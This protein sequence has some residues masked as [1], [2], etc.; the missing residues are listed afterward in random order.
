MAP[1]WRHGGTVQ[2]T[3]NTKGFIFAYPTRLVLRRSTC[4][5]LGANCLIE[6]D[7]TQMYP[8]GFRQTHTTNRGL[9]GREDTIDKTVA[10]GKVVVAVRAE[11]EISKTALTW[12][13]THV[14]R[15]GD[16]ITLLAVF[17]GESRG[18]RLW[19][20]PRFA[21]DC[22]GSHRET[23]P[24]RIYQIS[25]SCSQMVLQFHDQ[26]EV[27]IK[28][29]MVVSG[30]PGGAV[31]EESKRAGANWV[32]LDK[33]LK[34]EEKRCMEELHCNIVVMKHSQPKI[35][36]LNLGGSGEIEPSF[37]SSLE[38]ESKE[39]LESRVKH[40]TP[41]SSPEEPRTSFTRTTTEEASLSSSEA[42][43]SPFFVCERNPLFE[44]L[45]TGN[46]RPIH[47]RF[48]SD[49]SFSSFVL[50]KEDHLISSNLTSSVTRNNVNMYWIHQNHAVDK[51]NSVIKNYNTTRNTKNPT[52]KTLLE[53][54]VQF[55]VEEKIPE[56][57]LNRTPRIDH[58]FNSDVRDAV[59]LSRISSAPPPLCSLCRHRAPVFGKP[60]RWFDYRELEDATNG[61]SEAN[62]LA[63]GGF[64]LVH[65]GVLGDG[66]M[67]AVKQLKISGSQGDAE[68]RREV[69][70]LSC[71]QHRNVVMLVGF[72]IEGNKRVLVYEYVC[73]SSLDF[74]LYGQKRT[75]LD[76]KSRLKIAIGAA[77]GL[78]YL[79]EDCRVGCIV[80]RD[81]RPNNI[82]LT[83]DFEPLVADFGLARWQP[84]LDDGEEQ[85]V[86]GTLGY[87]APE[88]I[89]GEK[90]TEKADVYAFGVVLLE[91]ITGRKT[92][93]AARCKGQKFLAEC[94]RPQLVPEEESQD[95]AI[96]HQLLDPCLESNQLHNFSYQLRAMAQGA[97]L[98][99]RRDP[100]S[101]PSMSKVSCLYP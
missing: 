3:A 19:S 6:S 76:W 62:L 32:V 89:E 56:H 28:I 47:R 59:F 95:L 74:H 64:G 40:S 86:I 96:N 27:G 25:E 48:D 34:Q 54:F 29:K 2:K 101:R 38:L 92:I 20:F 81:M 87:L 63:E 83:H 36:R 57:G 100:E 49:Q 45:S 1:S 9:H 71:A 8:A 90:I 55:D 70:V 14:V 88:Y 53:K 99:L 78:R 98:C 91:L 30:S 79:H 58:V 4:N 41:V 10:P 39:L 51:Q 22:G 65:R 73:N 35:L 50:K 26:N 16:R 37:S 69:G 66:Q 97:S 80:H 46:S 60:P 82:L 84:G 85:R 17:S 11:K 52:S 7:A 23:S 33:H 21:G 15:P 43:T 42:D 68:F 12:A 24:D 18:R 44:G 67:V 94:S 5:A 72:C 77:R 93:G 31:A 61:F 13:L 75:P